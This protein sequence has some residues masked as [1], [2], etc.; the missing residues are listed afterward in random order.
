MHNTAQLQQRIIEGLKEID[1]PEFPQNLY[2]PIKY[3]LQIGGKRIRPLLTLLAADLFSV[4]D[5][6]NALPAALA[7]ELFHNF[8]L[9]HDDIMDNAPLRRGQQTVHEK[10]NPNVAIL[11]GDNLLIMAYRQLAKCPPE[12]LPQLLEAFNTMA[13]EVCEGQQLDMDFENMA[14]VGIDDYLRMIRLKTSV[15][16]GTALKM[17]AILGNADDNDAQHLYDFGVNVGLAFQ[18][19]DDILDVYGDPAQF[20]KQRGGDILANKKTY[21]LIKALE[22]AGTDI[23]PELDRWLAT[24]G[25]AEAKVN[26]VTVLYDRL[27]VRQAAELAKQR[28]IEQAYAALDAIGVHT[29]RKTPLRT[30]A[31]TLLNRTS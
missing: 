7:V 6:D 16:L 30:L 11:S 28:Y 23:R 19:Q 13:T 17:G 24:D 27:G 14:S 1:M 10:W 21:L 31:Q 3:L 26:A 9:M 25:P 2:E 5:T 12:K 8:S 15:L 20:G 22:T 18:L 29:T 4:D